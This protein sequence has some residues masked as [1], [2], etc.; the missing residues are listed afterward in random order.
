MLRTRATLV[1]KRSSPAHSGRPSKRASFAKPV[2][3]IEL[4]EPLDDLWV[5]QGLEQLVDELHHLRQRASNARNGHWPVDEQCLNTPAAPSDVDGGLRTPDERHVLDQQPKHPLALDSA[6]SWVIPH[7]REVP[8]EFENAF[9]GRLVHQRL[10]GLLLTLMVALQSIELTQPI[11]PLSFQRVGHQP[12]VG[13]DLGVA[14]PCQ[15]GL[16]SGALKLCLA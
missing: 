6:G 12:V 14:A 16:I 1:L 9:A 3:V 11:V 5:R 13:I 10:V 7:A 15:F 2:A 4:V 8:R